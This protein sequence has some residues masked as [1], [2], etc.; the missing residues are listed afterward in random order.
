M[1]GM[2]VGTAE[3]LSPEQASGESRDDPRSDVYSVAVL[4]YEMATGQVPFRHHSAAQVL[5]KQ[6]S[7]A[8]PPPRTIAPDLPVALERVL[9]HA[10]QKDPEARYQTVAELVDAVDAAMDGTVPEPIGFAP[11]APPRGVPPPS[12]PTSNGAAEGGMG[13][14]MLQIVLGATIGAAMATLVWYL[15]TRS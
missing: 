4:L 1:T 13:H 6:V 2:V 11:T 5:L 3:Y 14:L 12:D 7:A 9:L 8:P 15:L 10:L